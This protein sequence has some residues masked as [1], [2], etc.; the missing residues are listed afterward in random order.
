MLKNIKIGHRLLILVTLLSLAAAA[1]GLVGLRGM[2][3]TDASLDTVFNDR[4]IP[5]RD[6][7]I[8][9]DMYAVNIVDTIHKTRNGAL[10]YADA[11]NNIDHASELIHKKWADYLATYL[12]DE[13]RRLV[14]Q[15][16][17]LMVTADHEVAR[18]RAI[19]KAGDANKLTEFTITSLYPA[20]DPVSEKFS[21]LISVQI[22][23]SKEEY[24][25]SQVRY[26]HYFKY[27][28]AL[29]TASLVLGVGFSF[30]IIRSI[31]SP[32]HYISAAI[33]RLA[34]GDLAVDLHNDGRRDEI[35]QM[36]RA[37]ALIVSTLKDVAGDL[38]EMIDAARSGALS[39]RTDPT[40]QSGEFSVL[41]QG[42]NDLLEAITAPLFEVATVMAKLASGDVRGRISG[43]YEGDLR[44]LK[45]N[46]NRSLDGLVSL[47]EEISAFAGAMASGDITRSID[48]SYQGDFATIKVNLNKAAAQLRSVLAAVATSTQH[49]ANSAAETTAAAI[50][51]SRQAASQMV[52][53]TEVSS[54]IEQTAAAVGEIARSAERA[55]TLAGEAAAAAEVGQIK[56]T[57]LSGAVESIQKGNAR[58]GQ[59][60]G[61]ISTIADK[62]YVLAL[63]AGLEAARAGDH[64]RGFGLIAHQIT[65]LSEDVAQA[66][67][68]IRILIDEATNNVQ[69]GVATTQAAG[70]A[71]TQIVG[72]A[73]ESG[74]TVQ[75]IAAAI[76]Q[77]N[78]MTQLLKERVTHL[79]MVG[80]NTAGAAEEISATMTSLTEMAQHLRTEAACIKFS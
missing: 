32:V 77:Q 13:E 19:L 33:E 44:A 47:L 59:I 21:D 61:L 37:A 62:T 30:A 50:D 78:A 2:A 41:L 54:A 69:I 68:D 11:I 63:N 6:L 49:V 72:A 16:E 10:S 65:K 27:M 28:I 34:N 75:A 80:H 39:T 53:L 58:I 15:L 26:D 17:P 24:E 12:V 66:T 20:I 67:R 56:L 64:G 8:I 76:D 57:H 60:S 35:G 52:T 7:K 48:G 3:A 14:K 42:V 46:V 18:V 38:G 40:R 74:V 1:I 45:G 5:L 22:D 51:V 55:S 4:V 70:V 71:M 29:L 31:T 9:A 73:R 43:A 79:R 36:M 23:V 25:I